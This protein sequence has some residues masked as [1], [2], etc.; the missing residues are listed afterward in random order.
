VVSA[1][2]INSYG[3]AGATRALTITLNRRQ[4][5]APAS[6]AGGRNGSVVEFEWAANKERDIAGYRVYRAPGALQA[7]VKVCDLTTTQTNCQDP[8]P[9]SGSPLSYYVVALDHDSAGSLREGDHSATVTVNNTNLAPNAPTNLL[10]SPSNGNTVLAWTAATVSDADG[11]PVAF[12]RIYRDGQLYAN[13]Y[14]RTAG[15]QTTYTDSNTGGTQHSYSVTAVDA[16]LDESPILGPV[17]R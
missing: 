16:S 10:A 2:A 17:T 1:R 14:D 12:Y 7:D 11:D 6:V 13:R 8:S 15:A 3:V 4:P 5:Y 9:P